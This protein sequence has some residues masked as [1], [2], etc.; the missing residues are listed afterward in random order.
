MKSILK[1]TAIA[2]LAVSIISSCRKKDDPALVNPTTKDTGKVYLEFFNAVGG[3]N[4]SLNNQ[5]YKNEHGDSFT[6]SKFNYYIS[7]VALNSSAG[8]SNY[9]EPDSYHL[10]EH[11]SA[12]SNM[13]FNM[14]GIP[15]GKYKSVTFMIGVDSTRNVS[16]A[17]TGALDPQLG[18]FW[19]WHSGYIMLKF[20][21]K[22]PKSPN[23]DG[24]V[25]LHSGGFSGPNSVLKTVTLDFPNEVEVSKVSTPH[26]HLQAD[27]LKMFKSPNVI[28]FSQ[29]ATIHM[30]GADA[31][32]L[33]DNYVNMFSVTYAGL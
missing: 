4:L 33:S 10:I 5:W 22:S 17:Q 3:N 18:N 24:S 27:L 21:G 30:P 13:A 9:T 19:S 32:K 20:E 1:F 6:V 16:G 28:D 26:I 2:A 7:N 31:K 11:S 25:I 29:T 23:A 8:S 14:P 15:A 12:A